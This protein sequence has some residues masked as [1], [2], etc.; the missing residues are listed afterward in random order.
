M[1]LA[2][3]RKTGQGSLAEYARV[4]GDHLVKRPANVSPTEAAG[5]TL[6]GMTAYMALVDIG[7]IEP[8]QTVFVNGGSSSVGGFAIQIAKAKGCKVVAAC[9]G[10]NID[11]VKGLGADEVRLGGLYSQ[12]D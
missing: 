3:T 1:M 5:I 2:L 4:T 8:G 6:A 10:K 7:K 11:F 12:W 9:S